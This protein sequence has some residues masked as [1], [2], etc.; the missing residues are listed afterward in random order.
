M[1]FYYVRDPYVDVHWPSE[2]IMAT[3]GCRQVDHLGKRTKELKC[4]Y[5]VSSGSAASWTVSGI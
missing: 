4:L 3:T 1:E 5:R 2:A